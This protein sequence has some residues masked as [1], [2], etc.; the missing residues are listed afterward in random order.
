MTALRSPGQE[1][2][3]LSAAHA[4]SVF[5]QR[6]IANVMRAILDGPVPTL[7]AEQAPRRRAR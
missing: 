5:A 2:G 7:D 6:H 1:L 3:R 4:T